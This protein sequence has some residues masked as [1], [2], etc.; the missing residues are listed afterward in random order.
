MQ[1]KRRKNS[2]TQRE[3]KHSH[4]LHKVCSFALFEEDGKKQMLIIYH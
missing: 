4:F 3:W 2:N 1:L